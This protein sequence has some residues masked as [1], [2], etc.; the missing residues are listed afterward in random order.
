MRTNDIPEGFVAKC[1]FPD[2]IPS[3][4]GN[5]APHLNGFMRLTGVGKGEGF[6]WPSFHAASPA[7]HRGL[8]G[9]CGLEK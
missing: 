5:D 2:R 4:P 3:T 8:V 6:P 7:H 1:L 9:S